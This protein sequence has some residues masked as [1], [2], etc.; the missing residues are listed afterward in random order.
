M[1]TLA[2]AQLPLPQRV[3]HTACAG[4]TWPY[5]LGFLAL[6]AALAGVEWYALATRDGRTDRPPAASTPAATAPAPAP[7]PVIAGPIG[8]VDTPPGEALRGP[9]IA[10]AGWALA[11]EGI[12]GVELRVDGRSFA[13]RYGLARP[14]VAK[15]RP[16]FPDSAAPGFVIEADLSGLPPAPGVDRRP[17]RVVAIA[18]D[19][20][21]S[22]LATRDIV[23]AA[24][25]ERFRDLRPQSHRG[26]P[27]YILP[28]LSGIGLGGALELDGWYRPYA[29]PTI[30]TGMRVPILYLRTTRG[31]A[32]D[33]V[34]DPDWDIE[35]RCGTRRIAED[36]LGPSLRYAV[37]HAIPVLFTLN[38]GIWADA[39][40]DVPTWDV[41]DHLEQDVGND[42]WNEK[43]EV[44][45]DDYLKHL[46]GSQDAPELARSLT[47]NV[48]AREVRHYK[49][50]NLQAAGRIIAAF[51]KANP[52]LFVGITLD[53]DT[54]MNPFFDQAQWYDYNPQTLRQFREWL[55]G[56]G[57]YAGRATDGAPDLSR[58]RRAHPLTL[59]AVEK[60]AGRRFARWDDV[61][62]PRAFPREPKDGR[63]AFWDDPWTQEW[64]TFRRHVIDLHYD[65]LSSWLAEAGISPARIWSSQG[66]MAPHPD[67][68][69]F[70][71]HI[72][73][74]MKNYDTGGMSVEG[75]I[76]RQGHLGAILYGASAVNAI[77]M[78]V[79][80]TLF[81][82]FRTMD[83]GWG[84]V[85][86]NTADLRQPAEQPSY[87]AGY[88]ALR[89][90]FNFGGRYV[91]PM[92][93]NGSN[94]TL[95]GQ[96]GYV[97]FTAWRNTPFEDA[98][99][100][101]MLSHANVPLGA[102]LWTFGSPRHP[103]N[104]G[105]RAAQGI[106]VPRPGLLELVPERGGAMTLVS[107][108]ELAFTST[109]FSAV[110]LGLDDARPLQ[111]VRIAV[112]DAKSAWRIVASHDAPFAMT[113][114]GVTIRL[115]ARNVR[116]TFDR[117]R[118]ELT[119]ADGARANL[120]RIA[121]WPAGTPTLRSPKTA[122]H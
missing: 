81:N 72:G 78:E 9:R 122:A 31:Q 101:F 116:G 21:E 102:R 7:T 89:D 77:R 74:P 41:N 2:P 66:F 4:R 107:P 56:T 58:Y 117:M 86:I 67:A 27:F 28:A 52:E 5:F 33:F 49:R 23:E 11:P 70:A 20:R 48:Y 65:E 85:E 14:D 64:E 98:A 105:W 29:S 75:A 25:L 13:A 50:R 103:D 104:D 90:I 111:R 113:S 57:P 30:T 24:A 118:V 10:L 38:G 32:H 54:Y 110:V 76:P 47:F 109:A 87:A 6:V 12:R 46:P 95:A 1:I 3:P 112:G 92:A 18:K 99:R 37:L 62:P 114:A 44:L 42:Q 120:T 84:V 22:V 51:A 79:P 108:P 55:A 63:P 17:A 19:G 53:P 15:V 121:L 35:R 83:P 71:V 16:G 91:S 115:D 106:V 59:A 96:P 88:R 26:P 40:C 94:G 119:F 100:D 45:P 68:R 43:N 61:D 80:G 36:A 69:P 93:W 82:T 8:S 39:S 60:L 97:T 34:F 73:S